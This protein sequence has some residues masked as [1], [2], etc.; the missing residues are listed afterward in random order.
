[1]QHK[2]SKLGLLA[3]LGAAALGVFT[4]GS[5][6][7]AGPVEIDFWDQ[8]WG[9]QSYVETAGK[10][11]EKFN[12]SQSDVKV[13]YRSVPWTNWYQTYL[14]AVTSKTAPC[15]STGAGF[16][17][18]QL[19]DFD[20]ILPIDDFVAEAKKSGDVKDFLPGTV[21]SLQYKGHYIAWPWAVDTRVWFYRKDLFK[22]DGV[23]VPTDWDELMV[24]AKKLT[25]DKQY[26]FVT[27]GSGNL[28]NHMML[29][30]MLNNNGN[31][32][33]K[34]GQLDID[35]PRNVEALKYLSDL[36]KAGTFHPATAGYN[37]DQARSVFSRGDAAIWLEGVGSAAQYPDLK[38]KLAVLPPLKS[39]NGTKSTI[40]WV[41][42]IML[43]TNCKE[44]AA[45]K[46]FLKWYTKNELPLWTEGNAGVSPARKSFAA[47]PFFQNDKF[48]KDALRYYGGIGRSMA[49]K[50]SGIF[51]LL[52]QMD[53]DVALR[54]LTTEIFQGKD[55][56]ASL[57]TAKA[58]LE[59]LAKKK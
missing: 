32:F 18:A 14:T 36:V 2:R 24:A 20:G 9:P 17:A 1:M 4:I 49:Y 29:S 5:S 21:D 56:T 31:F 52:N 15:I 39:P 35:N 11:V 16:Q 53:G 37:D 30:L 51:P 41:N 42:N 54:N 50:V 38:D 8:I 40:R 34:D 55:V 26:A 48:Q 33:S 3:A 6:R 10:L 12:A 58:N 19:Y 57:A 28:G 45:A 44:P 13:T 47:N 27:S 46:A 7:A 25:H 59:E 43:Y 22:K 23:K